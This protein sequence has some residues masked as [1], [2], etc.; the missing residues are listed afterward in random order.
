MKSLYERP[1]Q[2]DHHPVVER[3][4]VVPTPS[5][6]EVYLHVTKLI[7]IGSSGGFIYGRSQSGK[8]YSIRYV[9]DVLKEDFPKGVFLTFHAR[10]KKSPSEDMFFSAMLD[11]ANHS[12][13]E[14]GSI[15]VKRAKLIE[16]IR[17]VVDSS[18]DNWFVLFVDEAQQLELMEYK[19]LHNLHKDL[20]FVGV[21]MLTLLLGQP[22]LADRKRAFMLAGETQIVEHFMLDELNFRGLRSADDFAACLAG[23]DHMGLPEYS[24][25]C[26]TRFFFPT[27]YD[28]G[29]RLADSASMLRDVFLE[30]H[31][32]FFNSS[33]DVPMQYFARSVEIAL[34][35]N[36]ER[37]EQQFT[38]TP[39]MW[40]S[41]VVQ[42]N[43]I[44]A[45]SIFESATV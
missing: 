20:E 31:K 17:S 33:L 36:Y 28:N 12:G 1:L 42:S 32:E 6:H 4:Y 27:A 19:W 40:K 10:A 45:Q 39:T 3:N 24:D 34:L 22:S 37:D 23:Y 41:A 5:I 25:W 44:E 30:V 9:M 21:R 18:G 43:F 35:E 16:Q 13:A 26:H 29:F 38:I 15:S 2:P 11:A 14:V 7:R 8:T